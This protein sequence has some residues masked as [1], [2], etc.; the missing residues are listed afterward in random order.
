MHQVYSTLQ[1][2]IWPALDGISWHVPE[3]WMSCWRHCWS[4]AWLNVVDL[5]ISTNLV[6]NFRKNLLC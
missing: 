1:Q 6:W 3:L 5:I 4:Y 2:K